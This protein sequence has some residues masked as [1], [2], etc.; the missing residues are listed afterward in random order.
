MNDK[1]KHDMLT[2]KDKKQL[3]QILDYWFT[4]LTPDNWFNQNDHVDADIQSRFLEIYSR[5][6]D[7][8][9]TEFDL[10]AQQLLALILLFDQMP[11]N[12]FRNSAAAFETDPLAKSLCYLALANKLD[13]EMSDIQKAFIYLPLE[14]SE[15]LKDQELSVSLF[16]HRTSLAEQTDYAIRHYT[17]IHKFGRF[18]HRNKI[19]G[20]P[21]TQE[22]KEFLASGGDNFGTKD[23]DQKP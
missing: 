17:I 14:H 3:D 12:M 18:P 11:R 2:T 21:S 19:L 1:V 6:K 23:R 16:Q 7:Q 22:E 10:T 5:L 15:D 20:R 13:L 9:L 8:K 4:Q